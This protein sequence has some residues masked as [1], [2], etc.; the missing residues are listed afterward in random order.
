MTLI[1]AVL[2]ENGFAL[3]SDSCES[4]A[5]HYIEYKYYHDLCVKKCKEKDIK[6]EDEPSGIGKRVYLIE[7]NILSPKDFEKLLRPISEA[8]KQATTEKIYAISTHG[9]IMFSGSIEFEG[10]NIVDLVNEI[11]S[12]I[13]PT[14]IEGINDIIYD[15][16]LKYIPKTIDPEDREYIFCHYN[17]DSK[18]SHH[19]VCYYKYILVD[20]VK[21]FKKVMKGGPMHVGGII[22]PA[23]KEILS[24]YAT[25]ADQ[26]KPITKEDSVRFLNLLMNTTILSEKY[27]WNRITVSGPIN[28][29]VID[30]EGFKKVNPIF[31]ADFSR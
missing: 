3:V 30:H 2:N 7:D 27:I 26:I 11:N 23:V 29:Y 5:G 9:A 16:I 15:T 17:P 8:P 1:A 22:V 14:K 28:Y 18:L 12:Q 25:V 21:E 20:N 6:L 19:I 24:Q 31:S 10:S 13:D 4:R